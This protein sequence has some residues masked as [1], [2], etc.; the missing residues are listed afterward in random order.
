MEGIGLCG[1]HIQKLYTVYLTR[2]LTYK[3]PYHPK[4]KP[5]R[6]GGL[7]QINTYR[8]VPL[9]VNF[10]EK[11]TFRIWC[12]Y[13]YLVYVL[14]TGNRHL[15]GSDQPDDGGEVEGGG[16]EGDHRGGV[17]EDLQNHGQVR[18]EI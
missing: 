13:S 6:G 7:R 18:R 12:L 3:L 8:Q 11:P 17:E 14:F 15:E 1:E 5:R 2:F 4:Q 10:L 9:Q 16:E